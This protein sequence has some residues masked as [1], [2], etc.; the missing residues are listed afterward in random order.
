ML[1]RYFSFLLST[2]MVLMM[3]SPALASF[4]DRELLEKAK[5]FL[6]MTDL[7]VTNRVPRTDCRVDHP[8]LEN[9]IANNQ[10]TGLILAQRMDDDRF[11]P[12]A[13][14]RR[15]F[16]WSIGVD[17]DFPE[18][19]EIFFC[20]A[21]EMLK[22]YVDGENVH[23]IK[24]AKN[25]NFEWITVN[26]YETLIDLEIAPLS[27]LEVVY[28]TVDGEREYF[29]DEEGRTVYPYYFAYDEHLIW[30]AHLE[31]LHIE[32]P[33]VQ[34]KYKYITLAQFFELMKKQDAHTSHELWDQWQLPKDNILRLQNQLD[35]RTA[36]EYER[37]RKFWSDY[38]ELWKEV[39]KRLRELFQ[40][41]PE[42]E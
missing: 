1:K 7:M 32:N 29:Y 24:P 21:Y 13:H 19:V 37:V 10:E 33:D 9:L 27:E 25:F 34:I 8:V 11:N 15:G 17:P 18:P 20:S 2:Q 26:G 36:P 40:K 5:P 38:E 28:Y 42:Q 31:R 41:Y 23:I 30:P 4:I 16:L 22:R 39:P 12:S 3:C 35:Y 6:E 14:L